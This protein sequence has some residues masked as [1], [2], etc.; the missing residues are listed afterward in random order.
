[1]Q[2]YG[3]WSGPTDRRMRPRVLNFSRPLYIREIM[4]HNGDADKPIW[5]TEMNWNAPPPDLPDRPFGFVTP[6]QQARYAVLAYQRAQQEWPWMGVINFWFFKRA[7]DTEQ[8]QAMYYFRMVEPDFTPLPVYQALKEYTHSAEPR[9]LYP[10]VRQED[11]WALE[12]AGLWEARSDSTAEAGSY[13]YTE[14]PQATLTFTFEGGELWLK[15]GPDRNGV[16]SYSLDGGAKESIS[17]AAGEALQ[18]AHSLPGERHTITI[19]ADSGPLSVDSITVAKEAPATPWLALGAAVVAFGLL[20]VLV[21]S[22]VAR[23]R[24]WY[25][26]SRAGR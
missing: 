5:L 26:R 11:H 25:E 22:V 14:D 17:F 12:Y 23:R 18:L 10:G 2:G 13:R 4:V 19:R 24:R 6:E 21:S 9:V 15:P 1:M 20:A 7:T 16:F 8:D 3:L